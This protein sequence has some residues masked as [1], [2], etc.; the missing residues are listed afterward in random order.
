[1]IA[2]AE[3]E[4]ARNDTSREDQL[5]IAKLKGKLRDS[6][7]QAAQ[8][9]VRLQQN[10]VTIQR[11]AITQQQKAID[12]QINK[13]KELLDLFIAEQGERARTLQEELELEEVFSQKRKDI[14]DREL[15]AKKISEE[16]YKTSL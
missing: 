16:E 7:A 2:I 15:A 14:L 11:E 1:E 12:E 10:L 5:E 4:A 13:Q 8:E 3:N 6:D 9:Q